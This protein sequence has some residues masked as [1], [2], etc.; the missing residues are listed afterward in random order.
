MAAEERRA[1]LAPVPRT[2]D[3]EA[4]AA[5]AF[6]GPGVTKEW[7]VGVK[8]LLSGAPGE[9]H[10]FETALR[11]EYAPDELPSMFEENDAAATTPVPLDEAPQEEV[12]GTTI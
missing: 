2:Q 6:F 3:E 12:L 7:V 10:R 8:K 1:Q 11:A 9:K 5:A 4:A